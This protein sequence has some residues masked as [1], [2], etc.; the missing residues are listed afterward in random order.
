MPNKM[1]NIFA[2]HKQGAIRLLRA[3][4]PFDKAPALA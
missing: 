4:L 1:K 3:G 2:V